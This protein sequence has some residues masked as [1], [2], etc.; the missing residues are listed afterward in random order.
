MKNSLHN[1]FSRDKYASFIKYVSF[2]IKLGRKIT[3]IRA[4]MMSPESHVIKILP[5]AI[6]ECQQLII[7]IILLVQM[8][9]SLKK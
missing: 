1:A 2:I 5:T 8:N 9:N 7:S 3:E 6:A 4:K